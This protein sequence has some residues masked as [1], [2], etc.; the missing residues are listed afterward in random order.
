MTAPNVR[1]G[2]LAAIGVLFVWSGFIVFSRA[3]IVAGLTPYDLVAMR[4][5]VAGTLTLPFAIAWWP[6]HLPVKVQ[7]LLAAA[8][9]GAIYST[10]MFTGLGQSSAAYGGVFSNGAMPIFTMLLVLIVTRTKPGLYDLLSAA[11]IVAGGVMVAWRGLNAG[12]DNVAT[13]ITLFIAASAL[14]SIYIYAIRHW[15]VTPKQVLAVVNIPNAFVF[16]PIWW[17]ALPSTMAEADWEIVLAQ[18]AFQGLGP[19]FLA[20]IMFAMVAYHLGPTPTAAISATV[21]ATA[22]LL[23]VPVLGEIPTG[24]EWAGIVTVSL[25]LALA[26]RKR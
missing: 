25:G 4:F 18:L 10:M 9:P 15:Q 13:G 5:M 20:L 14:I 12:G 21:P 2:L 22:A 1:T 11:V 23:A 6:R 17:T 7:V 8:G 16:L 26:M 19:G 3:G 24:F